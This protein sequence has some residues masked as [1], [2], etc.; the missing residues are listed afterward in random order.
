MRKTII[1]ISCCIVLLLLGYTGYRGYQVWKENHLMSLAKV[2]A[3]REDAR[4][5]T[6]CL[7]QVLHV[8]PRNLEACRR[9]AALTEGIMSP[10]ALG[11]RERAVT[12][13]PDSLDDRLALVQTALAF[14]DYTM[15]TSALSAVSE[16]DKKTA[17]YQNIAGVMAATLNQSAEA[18]KHFAEAARLEPS[19]PA[20]Q[21]NLAVIRLH[22]SNS[23]DMAAARIELKRISLN[24][25][26]AE[27][28][29]QA[30]RELVADAVRSKEL[31]A[32][33]PLA[34][35]LTRQTNAIFSDKLL[36]LDILRETKNPD[37]SSAV[38]ECQ[39]EAIKNG[40]NLSDM[41]LWLILRSTPEQALKWLQSLPANIQTNQPAPMIIAQYQIQMHDWIGAQKFLEKQDWSDL[42][43]YRH[44]FLARA[45]RGQNLAGASA[46]EWDQA[47]KSANNQRV[48]LTFLFRLS[49]N[50]GWIDEAEQAL[51]TIVSNYPEEKWAGGYLQQAL[52]QGG[53]TLSLLKLLSLQAKRSP[54][55]MD[56]KNNLAMIAMLLD[57]QELKPYDLAQEVYEKAPKNP[58]YVSTYALALYLQKKYT[59]SLK[60]I[61]QL[62]SKELNN[63][64]NA[65]YYGLILKANGD[66]RAASYLSMALKGG[67]LPEERKLFEQAL[68]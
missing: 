6:L 11:W 51:W 29:I 33:L 60:V 17:S 55:D 63:P 62:P 46:A 7:Q 19:N 20:I 36:R 53:R 4:N 5:E 8:N 34:T 31:A 61:E 42:D 14:K 3:Q 30:M 32:A 38:A 54:E 25:T 16:A 52:M 48:P 1:A 47:L 66:S 15:A 39:R 58:G 67:L 56:T 21:L 50:W 27:L 9:M 45:L 24:T 18:E 26:N 37:Y 49:A 65:G 41:A 22:G 23:L 59:D 12:L 64:E 2:F 57:A 13:A 10:S 44:A 40:P 28:R 68:N 35:E 43:Y